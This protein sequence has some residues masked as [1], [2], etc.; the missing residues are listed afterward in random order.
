ML[1]DYHIK[2]RVYA[3]TKLLKRLDKHYEIDG[4]A[5]VYEKLPIKLQLHLKN[6]GA[7]ETLLPDLSLFKNY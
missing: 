3:F 4:I 5:V 2:T 1:H 6:L 7:D